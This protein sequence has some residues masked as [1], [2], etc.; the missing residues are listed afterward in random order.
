MS[1]TLEFSAS[2]FD[3]RSAA[4]H[5]VRVR[6]DAG[7]LRIEGEA[8]DLAVALAQIRAEPPMAGSAH[9]LRLPGGALLDT[10]DAE[11]VRALFPD[12]V[13]RDAWLR[14][15]EGRWTPALA[16]LLGIGVFSAWMVLVVLPLAAAWAATR[17]PDSVAKALGEQTLAV[18]DRSLCSPSAIADGRQGIVR[19][20]VF[21]AVVA[22]MPGYYGLAFR[23]CPGIGPNAFALAD[24]TIVVTDDLIRLA[25]NDDELGAIIAHEVGHVVANHPVRLALQS[26]GVAV[27]VSTLAGDA[28]SVSG[29]AV[30]IPTYLMQAGYSRQLEE[31]ADAF[32]LR[33]M[34]ETRISPE[35]F[36]VILERLQA[37]RGSGDAEA[38]YL[39]THPSTALRIERAR[40]LG[41]PRR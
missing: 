15:L 40:S 16:A 17:I 35:H 5:P 34:I 4:S 29:L 8:L 22:E 18:L 39:S 13:R 9:F 6:R 14:R 10:D 41:Q 33:R 21:A 24:G 23:A 12:D 20:G 25:Q 32:A 11:A 1:A 27:L 37:A 19:D 28:V 38:D 3:G 7:E 2:Y 26:A 30:A 36:A 31:E